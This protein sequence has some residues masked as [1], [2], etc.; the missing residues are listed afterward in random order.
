MHHV[1][2]L[3]VIAAVVLLIPLVVAILGAA[4]AGVLGCQVSEAGPTACFIGGY[5]WGELLMNMVMMGWL[6]LISMPI[7]MVV[8]GLWFASESWSHVR[9]RRRMKRQGLQP[10]SARQALNAWR[11]RQAPG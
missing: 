6:A 1:R 8:L 7:L 5:D 10:V 9:R 4:L 11:T 2:R 3:V